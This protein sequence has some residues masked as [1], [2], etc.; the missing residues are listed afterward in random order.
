V[1]IFGFKYSLTTKHVVHPSDPSFHADLINFVAVCKVVK[2]LRNVRLG[3][4][5][6]RPGA[7]NT[8]RYSEKIL[9]RNGISVVTV[10]LSQILGLANKLTKD[11][12]VVKERLEKMNSRLA[13]DKRKGKLT[14]IEIEKENS[15]DSI[16]KKI[17]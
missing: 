17:P 10:D 11:D 4:I 15:N 9:Q 12:N 2:G 3:A 16:G 1:Y 5:G 7:F 13:K 14:E 6:A 8:V